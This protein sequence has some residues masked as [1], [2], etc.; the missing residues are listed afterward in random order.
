MRYTMN[1]EPRAM[2]IREVLDKKF[3]A[4][5]DN[6]DGEVVADCIRELARQDTLATNWVEAIG[7]RL[8]IR[9]FL[10][11]QK[12]GLASL[13]SRPSI[14]LA[15]SIG[16]FFKDMDTS[17]GV[18][19]GQEL[20]KNNVERREQLKTSR[21]ER[22]GQEDRQRLLYLVE[23]FSH[24]EIDNMLS[25]DS[26]IDRTVEVRNEVIERLWSVAQT[27]NEGQVDLARQEFN[28]EAAAIN[29]DF[30]QFVGSI[31]SSEKAN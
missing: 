21:I 8:Q 31:L 29:N 17:L 11:Q 4:A 1:K 5:I 27:Y 20:S 18:L 16:N 6:K 30:D 14:D 15:Q 10:I 13:Y 28:I 22:L 23:G 24:Q 2:L 12:S 19:S 3:S 7:T 26:L 25:A 9:D